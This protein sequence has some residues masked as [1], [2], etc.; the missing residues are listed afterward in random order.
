MA[1][2]I[3]PLFALPLE[4]REIIYKKVLL[5]GAEGLRLLLVCREIYLEAHKFLF[6]RRLVFRS[7]S[8]LCGWLRMVPQEHLQ[9]VVEIVL[10]LQDVDLT[11]LLAPSASLS[12]SSSERTNS[13][14]TWELYEKEIERLTRAFEALRNVNIFTLRALSG[15]QTYLYDHFLSKFLLLLGSVYPTLGELSLEGNLHNQDLSFLRRMKELKSFSFDGFSASEASETT[16]ILSGLQLTNI[17][18]VSHHAALTPTH[19]RRS[20][21]T[22]KVRSFDSS[23]LRSINQLAA[24]SVSENIPAT[25]PA[26]F[27]TS[28][29]LGS[30]HNHQTLSSLSIFLS[31]TPDNET[32]DAL[33][34]FLDKALSIQ[35]LELDWPGLDPNILEEY[36]LLPSSLR[37]FW[38]R[39]TNMANAFSL[40]WSIHKSKETGDA[41]ELRK[42]VLVR[43]SQKEVQ[44]GA[45]T[46]R[47]HHDRGVNEDFAGHFVSVTSRYHRPVSYAS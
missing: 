11:P 17:S 29:I 27:F 43:S 6:Q 9:H 26:V 46:T 8:A 22:T 25:S 2:G 40:L 32:L 47:I 44:L 5:L 4:L 36:A 10:E 16:E 42:V 3:P 30:L 15:R 37:C 28:E 1:G 18:L 34:D 45:T 38:V 31:H 24:F 20:N 13:L 39:S 33:E 23:V 12:A 14:R 35:R 19:H 7:Q 21:F 41:P